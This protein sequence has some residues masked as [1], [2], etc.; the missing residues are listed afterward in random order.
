MNSHNRPPRP[1]ERSHMRDI[2][3]TA[4][5]V[6]DRKSWETAM[7][8]SAF[9]QAGLLGIPK[10]FLGLGAGFEPLIY[11][12]S[13]CARLVVATDLYRTPG[14]WGRFAPLDMYNTPAKFAP[15]N[16]AWNQQAILTGHMDMLDVR[17]GDNSFDGVFSSS[18]IEH[19]GDLAV[20]HHAFGEMVRVC[21]P[22]GVIA[23]ATELC[24]AGNPEMPGGTRLL[25]S[26]EIIHMVLARPEVEWLDEPCF[27]DIADL[28]AENLSWPLETVLAGGG[29]PERGEFLL[30]YGGRLFSTVHVAVR[31]KAG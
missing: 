12:L 14:D 22:G 21:K 28:L 30:T 18:S 17:F 31:K 23:F 11:Y 4:I 5:E 1:V 27:G 3:G 26:D 2:G 20:I 9:F 15:P 7:S 19:V 16:I 8:L 29:G 6:T 24:L 10:T 25:H 13:G